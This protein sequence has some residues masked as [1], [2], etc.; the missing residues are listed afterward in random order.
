[1][2]DKQD[3]FGRWVQF[4][5]ALPLLLIGGGCLY[6]A[7]TSLHSPYDIYSRK[8]PLF[9]SICGA[10]VCLCLAG[11]CLWYALAGKGNINRDD[12]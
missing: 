11:R 9:V 2:W 3:T 4:F 5:C 10:A 6:V 7:L 8:N 12:F 1:M